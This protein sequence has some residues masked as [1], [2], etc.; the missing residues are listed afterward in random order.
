MEGALASPPQATDYE[1]RSPL[2]S[3]ESGGKKPQ[4]YVAS[5]SVEV[6]RCLPRVVEASGYAPRHTMR[7][8]SPK[9]LCD[10][11]SVAHQT[12]SMSTE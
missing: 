9:R 3:W 8:I 7:V 11:I 5:G 2:M 6:L 12:D 10:H 1:T 4:T